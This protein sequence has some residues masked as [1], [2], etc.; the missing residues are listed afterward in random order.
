[1]KEKIAHSVELNQIEGKHYDIGKKLGERAR[2]IHGEGYIDKYLSLIKNSFLYTALGMQFE[3]SDSYIAEV[4]PI[5]TD[6][7]TSVHPKLL[8]EI[9]GFADGIGEDYSRFLVFT[10]NFGNDRGCSQFYLNGFLA[11]NYDDSP[12]AVDNEF[13]LLKPEGSYL[14]FGPSTSYIE[15]LDG[16]NE[17][18]LGAS[19]TFGA[20]YPPKEFGIGSAMFLR[21]ILD[22]AA[23]V[24]EALELFEKAPYVTPNNVLICD[25]K[26][27]AV[28]IEVSAGKHQIR[29]ADSNR[30]LICANSY[31][32]E[33]MK[34]QQRFKNPTTTWR[35]EKMSQTLKGLSNEREIMD[36]L[37]SDFPSGLFE[38]YY[39]F[40]L[41]TLWSV[42]YHPAD[43][44]VYLAIGEKENR[45]EISLNLLDSNISSRFPISLATELTD[46]DLEDRKGQF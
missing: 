27:N 36:F 6:A 39:S 31:Q 32:H 25:A 1:M 34:K 37:T 28:V 40:E 5:V 33:K 43:R 14:S 44:S 45:K 24:D 41:G 9:R 16:V 15:R 13:L 2:T 30:I 17:H 19:L 8:E 35:E 21:I 18:G 7:I 11:R 4:F 38:P 3:L 10:S 29:R 20:G 46:I 22:K 26:G 23:N 42:I 12:N